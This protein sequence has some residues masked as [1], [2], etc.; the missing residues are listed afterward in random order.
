MGVNKNFSC[1]LDLY[2]NSEPKP[3][4]FQL[5]QYYIAIKKLLPLIT[6]IGTTKTQWK[7]ATDASKVACETTEIKIK[8]KNNSS[9]LTHFTVHLVGM[10]RKLS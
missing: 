9:P 8:P 6:G 10:F 3:P 4:L 2:P 7:I 1:E 5:D